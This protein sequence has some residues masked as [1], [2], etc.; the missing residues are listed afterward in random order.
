MMAADPEMKRLEEQLQQTVDS[1]SA[2]LGEPVNG[3]RETGGGGDQR[4][5]EEDEEEDSLSDREEN[6]SGVT[7]S[8]SDQMSL[9]SPGHQQPVAREFSPADSLVEEALTSASKPIPITPSAGRPV[10][11]ET[12]LG[13]APT[14]PGGFST[15]IAARRR[16]SSTHSSPGAA[17]EQ[18]KSPSRP[19]SH[20]C[21]S[22]P[23]MIP[24]RRPPWQE[25]VR[26]GGCE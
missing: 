4:E 11:T 26:V 24:S 5:E 17:V 15:P 21:D 2:L 19:R 16:I 10:N 1:C 18:S 14:T 8:I 9:L 7:P 13:S 25:M 22:K 12:H 6:F 3:G 20:S 23:L